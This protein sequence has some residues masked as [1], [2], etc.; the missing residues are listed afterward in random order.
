MEMQREQRPSVSG[1]RLSSDCHG[2]GS[3]QQ[4]S[5]WRSGAH[6]MA[7]SREPIARMSQPGRCVALLQLD[8][9]ESRMGEEDS[10]ASLDGQLSDERGV[11][12]AMVVSLS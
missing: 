3:F 7:G 4:V 5:Y 12:A 10:V 9:S 6:F 11:L 1:E 2:D 8:E